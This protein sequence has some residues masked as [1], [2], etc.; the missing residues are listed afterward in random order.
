MEILQKLKLIG[1]PCVGRKRKPRLIAIDLTTTV[2]VDLVANEKEICDPDQLSEKLAIALK[3][4]SARE[5]IKSLGKP[6]SQLSSQE[7]AYLCRMFG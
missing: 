6:V 4:E 1:S 7:K 3:N 5:W 2:A